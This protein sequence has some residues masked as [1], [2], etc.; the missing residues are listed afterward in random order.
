MTGTACGMTNAVFEMAG[1]SL[2]GIKALLFRK[3]G[4]A[5]RFFQ[6][7][8]DRQLRPPSILRNSEVSTSS[9]G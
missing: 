3:P 9:T 4:E 1:A 8:S 7:R 2:P 5:F 6:N